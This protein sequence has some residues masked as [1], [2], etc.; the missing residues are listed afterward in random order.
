MIAD[1]HYTDGT[2]LTTSS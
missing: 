1:I 2:T